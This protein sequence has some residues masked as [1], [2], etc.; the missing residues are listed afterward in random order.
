[1]MTKKRCGKAR[2]NSKTRLAEWR[3]RSGITLAEVSGL[4]GLSTA[5]LCLVENGKKSFSPRAKLTVARRLGVTVQ[6]LFELER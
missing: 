3:R 1:M 4:T 2:N 6:E 5:M